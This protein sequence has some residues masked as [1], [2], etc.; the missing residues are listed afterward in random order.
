MFKIIESGTVI[1]IAFLLEDMKMKLLIY[2]WDFITKYDLYSEL[3]R[4]NIEY[5]LFQSNMKPRRSQESEQFRQEIDEVLTKKEYNAIFSINFFSELAEA[6]HE[7]GIKYI[8]WTY[9]SPSMTI[10]NFKVNYDTNYIFLFDYSEYEEYK[11]YGIKNIYYLPLAVNST[12]LRKISLTPI[13]KM[14]YYA[15]ISFVGQLY[16]SD[17]DKIFP[18]FDE[19]GAGYIAALINTQMNLH[20][21]RFVEE[22]VNEKIV[23]NICNEEAAKALS[24]NL[25]KGFS[26]EVDTLK[27]FTLTSF[28]LRAVTHKERVLLLTLLSKYFGVNLYSPDKLEGNNIGNHG[29]VDYNFTA[30][31]VFKASKINLNMTLRNIKTG[32]PQRVLDIM[33]CGGLALTN[34]QKDMDEYF[35]DQKNILI[36]HSAEEALE[37]TNYYLRHDSEREEIQRNGLELMEKCFSYEERLN[38][39]WKIA[40]LK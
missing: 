22:L 29:I 20:G 32:I 10:N 24:E 7:K 8:C 38:K 13:N 17:M 3:N 2:N 12:R 6:A 16:Q 35:T 23:E 4:Q 39:I 18:L 1:R 25:N 27:P 14:K 40:G 21:I 30:P 28:I 34:Y 31:L 5:D 33:G 37:K 9:D 11:E 26:W 19:Y 36:Y 15:D